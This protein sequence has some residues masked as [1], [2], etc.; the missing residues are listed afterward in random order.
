MRLK[1]VTMI[2]MVLVAVTGC[3]KKQEA[4]KT[5]ETAS[6]ATEAP[7]SADKITVKLLEAGAEPRQQLRYK[8]AAGRKDTLMMDMEMAIALEMA[9]MRQPEMKLPIMRMSM[10]ID[11]KNVSADGNLRYEFSLDSTEVLEGA[12]VNPMVASSMKTELEKMK[13]MTGWAVVTPR[14]FTQDAE[15]N[16]PPNAGQQV[17]QVI[18]NMRQQ[19]RQ[20][21][22]PLPEEAVGKGAKWVVTMPMDTPALKL[23]QTAEYELVELEGSKG[24]LNVKLVQNAPAQNMNVPNLPPGAS[25]RLN[26]LKSDGSGTISFDLTVP[27]PQSDIKAKMDMHTTIRAQGQQQDMKMNMKMNV[28]IWPKA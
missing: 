27:V 15:V 4:S 26:S 1:S 18:D 3:E 9:G 6:A 28:K 14:G 10:G 19:I 17:Q 23:T 24:K 5:G 7:A 11:S 2:L 13:G 21:S 16:V 22:S 25:A 8:F 12:G 20:M